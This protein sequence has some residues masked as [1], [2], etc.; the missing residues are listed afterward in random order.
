MHAPHIK[1]SKLWQL[2][3]S[4]RRNGLMPGWPLSCYHSTLING[5]QCSSQR[6]T[7]DY[8]LVTEFHMTGQISLS[9]SR[10]G[11]KLLR[12]PST[13]GK[14]Q[15][16]C[17]EHGQEHATGSA[18]PRSPAAAHFASI[19]C[20]GLTGPCRWELPLAVCYPTFYLHS[21]ESVQVVKQKASFL[22]LLLFLL[23]N[24]YAFY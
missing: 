14:Q 5:C 13:N 19:H 21:A 7:D 24:C 16:V 9:L 12:V 23:C 11:R 4:P 15:L 22:L 20:L 18:A 1:T 8:L 6:N 2:A 17:E 3:T 10:V